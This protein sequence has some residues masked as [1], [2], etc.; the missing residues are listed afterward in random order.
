MSSVSQTPDVATLIDKVSDQIV[1]RRLSTA[2]IFLLE[3][4][5]PLTTVGSQ[6]LIFLDPILK[7]F[8][9]VPDY[10]LF[11]ELLEDRQKVEELICAIERKEDAL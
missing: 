8:L 6:F 4:G 1:A 10:Q 2:A 3:S 5:K 11:I 9:T 7:I